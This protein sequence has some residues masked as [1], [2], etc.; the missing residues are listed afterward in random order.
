MWLNT[1]IELL[2]SGKN[3][4]IVCDSKKIVDQQLTELLKK[5]NAKFYTSDTSSMEKEKVFQDVDSTWDKL[6]AQNTSSQVVIVSWM[7]RG[8]ISHFS[9]VDK[10][11]DKYIGLQIKPVNDGIQLPEIFKERAI[12]EETHLRFTEVFGGKVFYVFSTKRYCK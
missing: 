11:N 6:V 1:L 3:I 2:D 9:V 12:Q 4:F 7:L 10:I 5:Y 8:Y